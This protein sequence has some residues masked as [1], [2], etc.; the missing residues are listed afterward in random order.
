LML[1]LYRSGSQAE[2]LRVYGRLRS[3]LAEELGIDPA[4]ATRA[5]EQSILQQD[6]SLDLPTPIDSV[7]GGPR[8]ASPSPT[9]PRP[10]SGEL[11][12]ETVTLL[13]TDIEGSSALW[14]QHAEAMD[15]ALA[16]H[17]ELTASVVAA[18]GGRV[19]KHRGEGDSV[20]AVFQ[21]PMDA[22]KAAAQLRTT[23]TAEP[24]PERAPISVRIAVATGETHTR[25]GDY[26]GST[27]NRAARLRALARGGQVLVSATTVLLTIDDLSADLRLADLG[28]HKLR[29]HRRPEHVFELLEDRDPR[30]EAS[31]SPDRSNLAW[32]L[33]S[34]GDRFVGREDEVQRL[35]SELSAASSG[36]RRIAV[37]GGEAGIGKTRLAGEVARRLHA[38]GAVVLYGRCDADAIVPYQPFVQ[39][40]TFYAQAC[41]TSLLRSDLGRWG[42][43]LAPMFPDVVATVG[44]ITPTTG[45]PE[46]ERFRMFEGLDRWLEAIA[47]RSPVVLVIDDLHWADQSSLLL[48]RHLVHSPVPAPML[49]LA[50]YR[51]T[52]TETP[53]AL[54]DF[55]ADLSR[56]AAATRLPLSGLKPAEIRAYLAR[57]AGEELGP[58]ADE[59]VE[60]LA[61]ETA[62]N[63]LFLDELMRHLIDTG[64]IQR[65]DGQWLGPTEALALVLPQSIRDLVSQRLSRLS[66][67]AR[68]A[69]V[70]AA[71]VGPEFHCDVVSHVTGV[72]SDA[73][74]EALEESVRARLLEEAL[75]EDRYVFRHDVVRHALYQGLSR[76]R[77]HQLH[78]Q[79]S[80]ALEWLQ[81][82]DSD[83]RLN[84]LAWHSCEG[85]TTREDA[86]RAASWARAAGDR[87]AEQLA[88]EAA[89][90]HYRRGLGVL[91]LRGG[92]RAVSIGLLL[93]L[94][95]VLNK[96]GQA[97]EGQSV[98]VKAA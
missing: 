14:D 48:L 70:V 3:I 67:P 85:A 54:T 98:F 46:A 63:P 78:R 88:F 51:D 69:I 35:E 95:A 2:A 91:E 6:P 60:A 21:R 32:S 12:T 11:A 33:T 58:D 83:R 25:D 94:G 89:A 90:D 7:S 9:T 5:L 10:D 31:T 92:D 97:G 49:V 28:L 75:G 43:A 93:E 27:V 13:L 15:I 81:L 42:P 22:I 41:P 16:R 4:P 44:G 20:F 53:P 1:A 39:A 34:P 74:F 52:A 64:A 65:Q 66:E 72:E 45:S 79:V 37:I 24:W 8:S 47:S 68:Q 26:L 29:D 84:E 50:T 77:R 57:V 82:D 62:G 55:L 73:C 18:N 23:L 61:R 56:G 96:S 40:M 17:D 71:V 86:E 19:V 76:H 38:G 87:A 80:L 30:T 59:I 36:I